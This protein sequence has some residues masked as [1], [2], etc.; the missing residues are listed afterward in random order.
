MKK[1]TAEQTACPTCGAKRGESCTLNTGQLRNTPHRERRIADLCKQ[2]QALVEAC[3]KA[4]TRFA[5]VTSL[6]SAV[7]GDRA[8]FVRLLAES[9]ELGQACK[10]ARSALDRHIKE[11][12]C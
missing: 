8:R 5:D 6:L 7:V 2:K 3:F 12:G 4:T 1:G 10:D 11:H 9:R